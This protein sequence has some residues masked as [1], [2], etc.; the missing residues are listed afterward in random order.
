M[1][2]KPNLPVPTHDGSRFTWTGKRGVIDES[3]LGRGYTGRLWNDSADAG[4]NVR[5][6][7]TG[8]VKTFAYH[9]AIGRLGDIQGFVYRAVDNS[10]IEI[11]VL[12]D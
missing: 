11:H 12:N 1:A 6:H 7:R 3:D 4:F 8:E 10:G 5:S 9:A 2:R